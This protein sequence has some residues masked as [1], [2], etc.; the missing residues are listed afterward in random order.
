[1][2]NRTLTESQIELNAIH[3][4]I[5][6]LH[7]REKAVKAEQLVIMRRDAAVEAAAWARAD[8][9]ALAIDRLLGPDCYVGECKETGVRMYPGN[10]W[11]C[12]QHN[13]LL[14]GEKSDES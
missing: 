7:A 2:S 9:V 11:F 10:R 13:Q 12:E 3:A 6:Y 1:M 4:A 5:D 8:A 14:K